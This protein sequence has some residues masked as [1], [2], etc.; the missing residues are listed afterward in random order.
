[1]MAET[2]PNRFYQHAARTDRLHNTTDD[3]HAAD[4]LGPAAPKPA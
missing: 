3:L 1:M 4:D 2:Y